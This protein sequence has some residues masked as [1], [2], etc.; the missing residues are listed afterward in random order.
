MISDEEAWRILILRHMPRDI[1]FRFFKEDGGNNFGGGYNLGKQFIDFLSFLAKTQF[2]KKQETHLP[3]DLGTSK[4]E[5]D[6]DIIESVFVH[7]MSDKDKEFVVGFLRSIMTS[8]CQEAKS[9]IF[10]S[11]IIK[12]WFE[13]NGQWMQQLTIEDKM[14]QYIK[15]LEQEMETCQ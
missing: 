13:E 14:E 1:V 7:T 12:E 6:L 8:D 15:N 2:A 5:Y 11:S 10:Q 3:L 4:I 9:L